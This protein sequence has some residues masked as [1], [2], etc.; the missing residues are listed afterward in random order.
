MKIKNY[1]YNNKVLGVLVVLM[2]A[3]ICCISLKF[4]SIKTNTNMDRNLPIYCVDT[5]EKKVAMSFD[6]SWGDDYTDEILDLLDKYKIKATFF[7]VGGWIDKNPEK[8]KEIH[9]RGHEIGN[10]T[11][12][13]PDMTKISNSRIVEEID[14][15]DAKIR[16]ITGQGTNLFRFPE[17]SYND[18]AVS[19]A[20]STGH[21]CVQWDVE[22]IDI[23]VKKVIDFI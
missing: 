23:K 9:N 13:H 17:G 12:M 4:G 10:H 21:Y 18:K 14:I 22:G 1:N 19:A 16:N 2:A 6:V 11:N 15:T 5:D 8:V 3:I 7:I 20:K